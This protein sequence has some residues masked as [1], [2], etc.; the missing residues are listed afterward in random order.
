MRTSV[1]CTIEFG[2]DGNARSHCLHGWSGPEKGF[3]WTIGPESALLLPR[4][5]APFGFFLEITAVPFVIP[6]SLPAQEVGIRVNGNL[7]GHISMQAEGTWS[8]YVPPVPSGWDRIVLTFEHPDAGRPIDFG[9]GADGRSL[10]LSM[11]AI[12]ILTLTALKPNSSMRRSHIRLR[13]TDEAEADKALIEV[14]SVTDIPPVDLV[15][16]FE[17]LGDNCEFGLFQRSC[18]AEP[19]GL[20]RFSTAW[21]QPVL[22]GL[23]TDFIGLGNP[24]H[25]DPQ[26]DANGRGEWVVYERQYSLRYHTYVWQNQATREQ[27]LEQESRKLGFLRRKL[28]ED[29][30]DGRKMFIYK[31]AI[32]PLPLEE[33]MPLFLALNRHAPNQLLWV[34]A[35]DAEHS[36][37][38]VEEVVP[39]LL[40]GHIDRFAPGDMV[41]QLSVSGWLAVCANAFL[42]Q[43]QI[44]E[45]S[46]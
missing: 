35:A 20:L 2:L 18:G 31:R 9:S 30:A 13:H 44:A 37:G 24:V 39:G 29:V 28:M 22:R 14:Q 33:V 26:L 25:V 40:R 41:P 43:R 5:A 17:T 11:R 3:T 12:R 38:L 42:L 10:A 7:V 16:R 1:D 19:L 21:L 45:A 4:P 36:V 23:D 8:L 46:A 15:T 34:V 6:G 32:P 27:I